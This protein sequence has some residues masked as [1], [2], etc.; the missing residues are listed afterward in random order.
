[1]TYRVD[2]SGG[3]RGLPVGHVS[4]KS[5]VAKADNP[6][7]PAFSALEYAP[8]RTR[9]CKDATSL[10]HLLSVELCFQRQNYD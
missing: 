6:H 5:N 8:G 7:P 9:V 3:N 1:M 2:C 10:L 4:R